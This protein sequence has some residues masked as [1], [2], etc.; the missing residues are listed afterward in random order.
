MLKLEKQLT[1]LIILVSIFF[2]DTDAVPTQ[3]RA[4]GTD[5]PENVYDQGTHRLNIS[6]IP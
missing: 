2:S 1:C 3:E 4:Y 6:F 5:I